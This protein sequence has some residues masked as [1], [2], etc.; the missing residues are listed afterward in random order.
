MHHT[1]CEFVNIDGWGCNNSPH[2]CEDLKNKCV[3]LCLQ[4]YNSAKHYTY[5][6]SIEADLL[7]HKPMCIIEIDNIVDGVFDHDC[8]SDDFINVSQSSRNPLYS[9]GCSFYTCS[10]CST[11]FEQTK[12]KYRTNT[13]SVETIKNYTHKLTQIKAEFFPEID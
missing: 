6:S 13:P 5:M 8:M 3:G 1:M 9:I 2:N 12:H 10:Y 11:C 7:K 4:H